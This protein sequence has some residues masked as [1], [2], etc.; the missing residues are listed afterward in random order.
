[1]ARTIQE[2]KQQMTKA[3]MQ[4]DTVHSKY[5]IKIEIDNESGDKIIPDFED[6]F[7]KSHIENILFYIV[8]F[9]IHIYER[10]FD[11]QRDELT[12]YVNA[13]RPHT[14]AWYIKMIK[15]YQE[16]DQFN[17]STGCYDTIDVEKQKVK[18]C[19]LST[20]QNGMLV[21]KIAGEDKEGNLIK[22]ELPEINPIQNY[23][24]RVKDAGVRCQIISN[25]PDKFTCNIDIIYDP[26]LLNVNGSKIGESSSFPV[27]DAIHNYFTSFP[28]NSIYSNMKLTDAIQTVPGVLVV[29]ITNSNAKPEINGATWVSIPSTYNP[30]AGYM[31]FEN[32]DIDIKYHLYDEENTELFNK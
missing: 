6:T 22:I 11:T 8:A 15:Q 24:D 3:W 19:A 30:R 27:L 12:T 26:I 10:L 23:I 25:E 16:G 7:K 29:Q 31:T 13:M 18:H 20:T 9:A 21:F 1:M 5:G 2:I 4:D 17:E 28:F 14:A 32:N